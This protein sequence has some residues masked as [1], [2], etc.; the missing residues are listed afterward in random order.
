MTL[1]TKKAMMKRVKITGRG[2]LTRRHCRINH[3][4]AKTSGSVTL[5][6]RTELSLSS[7]DQ[8]SAKK[9]IAN[10]T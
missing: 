4:N 7:I 6:R 8:K 5:H 1:K 3:F 2:K 10:R 9:M